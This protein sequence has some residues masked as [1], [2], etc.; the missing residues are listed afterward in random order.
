MNSQRVPYVLAIILIIEILIG[1]VFLIISGNWATLVIIGSILAVVGGIGYLAG[2]LGA[3]SP[4]EIEDW[5]KNMQ[6]KQ[7]NWTVGGERGINVMVSSG[8]GQERTEVIQDTIP[9]SVEMSKFVADVGL[10][11]LVV[12]GQAELKE[13]RFVATKRVYLSDDFAAR[14]ELER[15]QVRWWQEGSVMRFYAGQS[16]E[17]RGT[18]FNFGKNSRVDVEMVVPMGLFA[19]FST[20]SGTMVLA[21]LKGEVTARTGK[22]SLTVERIHSGRNLDIS[23]DAGKIIVRDVAVAL[24]RTKSLAGAQELTGIGAENVD[25]TSNAGS[26]KVRG[27]NCGSYKAFTNAGSLELSDGN[28]EG[29][30]EMHTNIGQTVAENC[31]A[32]AIDMKSDGGTVNYR[33]IAPSQDSRFTNNL[34]TITVAFPPDANFEL[35]ARSNLGSVAVMR[36]PTFVQHQS[37]NAFIGQ[38]GTGGVKIK[39][40]TQMGSVRIS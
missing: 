33:G 7:W 21:D 30:L 29:R 36:P 34:G 35:E 25:L 5:G 32:A 13:I 38:I 31:R 37:Q 18:T 10:G 11:S 12:R 14:T 20:A 16:P 22:G 3:T 23:S 15:L 8:F 24:L 26:V 27:I 9:L 1:L 39:A 19:E 6:D 28:I 17:F 4:V 40:T 2:K